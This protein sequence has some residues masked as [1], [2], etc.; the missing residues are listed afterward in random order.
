MLNRLFSF[1]AGQSE[2]PRQQASDFRPLQLVTARARIPSF[3]AFFPTAT[4]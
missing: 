4:E 2:A 3:G 1:V